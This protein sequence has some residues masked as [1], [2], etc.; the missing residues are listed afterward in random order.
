VDERGALGGYHSAPAEGGP[1]GPRI[2]PEGL[3][4]GRVRE[5]LSR[6]ASCFSLSQI[7][8]LPFA[9]SSRIRPGTPPMYF[10]AQWEPWHGL[11]HCAPGASSSWAAASSGLFVQFGVKSRLPDGRTWEDRPWAIISKRL[12]ISRNARSRNRGRQSALAFSGPPD[13]FA[14]WQLRKLVGLRNGR[15]RRPRHARRRR[16][17]RPGIARPR[18]I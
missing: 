5:S 10:L 14:G 2:G 11:G 3:S 18:L 4:A 8:N 1:P 12:C 17:L 16:I 6:I 15:L 7:A 13:S 9:T